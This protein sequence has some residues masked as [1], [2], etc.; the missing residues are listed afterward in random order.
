MVLVTLSGQTAPKKLTVHGVREH[1]I[2][3]GSAGVV[4]TETVVLLDNRHRDPARAYSLDNAG[5]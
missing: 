2:N 1:Q 5:D 4:L 3:I